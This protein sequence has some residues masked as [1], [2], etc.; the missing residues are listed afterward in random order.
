MCVEGDRGQEE[1]TRQQ[2]RAGD[3]QTTNSPTAQS[4][5]S[6]WY[7]PESVSKPSLKS[8][9]KDAKMEVQALQR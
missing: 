1:V 9:Y 8:E 2:F 6:T 5:N 4:G 7:I 3:E